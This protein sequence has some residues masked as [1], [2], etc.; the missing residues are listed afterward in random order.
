MAIAR[1]GDGMCYSIR[2]NKSAHAQTLQDRADKAAIFAREWVLSNLDKVPDPGDLPR[3][4]DEMA[5][6]MTAD[7]RAEGIRGGDM[8][9]ALGDLDEFLAAEYE[10]KKPAA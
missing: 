4:I 6:R 1:Y 3:A 5:C 7:A 10:S 2:M 8:V 9:R